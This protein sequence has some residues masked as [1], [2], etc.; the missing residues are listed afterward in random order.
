MLQRLGFFARHSWNDLKV[1]KQR[2]LFALLCIASGVAAIVSLQSLAVMMNRTL[3]GSLQETNHGDIRVTP[4]GTWG[5]NIV[6]VDSELSLDGGNV[7]TAEGVQAVR[8]WLDEHY[9]GSTLTYRQSVV[10]FGVA[11]SASIPARNTYKSFI[12]NFIVEADRYPL[13]GTVKSE[14]DELLRDLLRAPTDIVISRNLADELEAEVGDTLRLAGASQDFTVRGIVPSDA[15]AGFQ[16]ILASLFGYFYLDVRSAPLFKDLTPGNASTLFIRL[17]DP[18]QVDQA[19]RALDRLTRAVSLTTTSDI[20]NANETISASTDNLV[21]IMG[22]V[23]LLI[24]GVGIVNTMLVIVSRRTAEVAV[25]KTLGLEPVEVMALFLVEALLMGIAGSILGVLG[26]WVLAYL[27]KGVAE[28]FLGQ[29]LAF[30]IAAR[31]ALNG[32]VVGILITAIFGFLPT[33]AAGQIRPA[34]VLRPN[35]TIIPRAGRL[36]AFIAVVGLVLALSLVAQGLLGGLLDDVSLG[37]GLRVTT[38]S[39]AAGAACG[40][41]I[42][43][44]V[45]IGGVRSLHQRRR[46]RSWLLYGL[47]WLALLI[48]LPALG[49]LFGGRVPALLLLIV[50]ALLVG[51]LYIVLWLLIWA[52]GG[53]RVRDLWPGILA[54]LFPLFWPLI[55]VLIV[56]IVPMWVLGWL[57]Q[58]FTFVDLRLAMRSMLA[59]K[60]RGAST[61]LALV[62]GVFTLSI[63]TMLVDTITN[64]FE[65]LLESATGGNIMIVAVGGDA[66][67]NSVRDVINQ[68]SDYVREFAVV[69]TYQTELVNYEVART[70]APLPGGQR[71]QIRWRFET[72]DGRDL[73]SNL[74]DVSFMAGRNL[75]PKL[76]DQPDAD[77]IW[78][79][80]VRTGEGENAFQYGVGDVLTVRFPAA[81]LTADAVGLPR[82]ARFRIVGVMNELGFALSGSEMYAPLAAFEGRQAQNSVG[83]ATVDEKHIRDVRRALARVPGTFVLETRLINDLINRLVSQ[84]TSF[85]LLVAALSLLT[86]GVVIANSVALS[87]L[88]RRREIA[89]MKAVGLQRERVLGMLLL[90][91]GLLGIVG[92]LIGVG[93]SFAG[94]VIVLTQMFGGAL[95][96]AIPYATA[97]MLMALCIAIALGAALLSVWG[98][99][100]EKPLNVLRYE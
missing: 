99:S 5:R 60:G 50:T 70:G 80:V 90:E 25:L 72:L 24:G 21:V 55:P 78:S 49:A 39:Q 63:I 12:Y 4:S 1:N 7:F 77:G 8:D 85:P 41:A 36:S 22:L 37:G 89:V 95:G 18:S 71:S 94:L 84:F 2:T 79:A 30:V 62:V 20:K 32:F 83:I 16:N 86:G 57:I 3:T 44:A 69:A 96:S 52:V 56:L 97:F 9:P 64:I 74:P 31:P 17:A 47:V 82:E 35:E 46:G 98:A 26:G 19:A 34:N 88:E 43:L 81:R 48:G 14:R 58:R 92:G 65:E 59:T 27:V 15:E 75:D 51:Y 42:A 87:T 91:N 11:M 23:S 6:A 29:P 33:L 93:I 54:L 68:Q 76:D 45:I 13:Y 67:M 100:G 40:L 38:L 28:N 66:T 10:G 73:T 61:L 53:G